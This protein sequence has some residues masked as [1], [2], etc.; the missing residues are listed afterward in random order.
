MK[1]P[2]KFTGK[3]A[4]TILEYIKYMNLTGFKSTTIYSK[5][6]IVKALTKKLDNKK[7]E[8]INK[9]DIDAY[10]I[11]RRSRLKPKTV[12]NDIVD[13]RLFFKWF[14][15]DNTFFVGIKTKQPKNRLPTTELLKQEDVTQMLTACEN[16]RDRAFLI[17]LWDSGARVGEILN[18]NIRDVQLDK[19]GAVA[20]VDGKTGM[21]RLRL[22]DAVPDLQMWL[23]QHP[24]RNNP[25][26]PLFVTSRK[27]GGQ[28]QRLD[29]RT[30]Q[31]LVKTIADHAGIKKNVHC[32]GFRHGRLTDLVKLG[33]KESELRIIAGWSDESNMPAVYIHMSGDDVESKML[34]AHGIIEENKEEVKDNLQPI[35]CPRCKT[36][37]AHDAKYCSTCSMVLDMKTAIDED[38][39]VNDLIK[40]VEE[41]PAKLIRVLKKGMQ[42]T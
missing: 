41:D 2:P 5:L 7:F 35:E 9:N 24:Q 1:N 16:Q 27:Y 30:V 19:Y 3:N 18:L 26:A 25:D 10:I 11:D 4:E 38:A 15:P 36:K 29:I 42:Q 21:R 33:F 12:H 22:I 40:M 28:P 32:H 37:N 31:N 17:V 14:K 8:D 13:L 23:N 34:A 20:I 39:E 6:W